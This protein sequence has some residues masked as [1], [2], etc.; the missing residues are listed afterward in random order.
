MKRSRNNEMKDNKKQNYQIILCADYKYLFYIFPFAFLSFFRKF[1]FV[2]L[3]FLGHFL[4]DTRKKTALQAQRMFGSASW[5]SYIR[6]INEKRNLLK[7]LEKK[8]AK[9][10]EVTSLA[11]PLGDVI[12]RYHTEKEEIKHLQFFFLLSFNE[13]FFLH[14]NC[15]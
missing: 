4:R 15:V 7:L 14:E 9:V 1:A 12:S 2:L 5:S 8:N 11:V 3:V 13:K 6:K 10:P